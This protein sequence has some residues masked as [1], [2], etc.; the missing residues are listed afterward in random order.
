M[1]ATYVPNM[2]KS[3]LEIKIEGSACRLWYD[4]N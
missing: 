1:L 4:Q 3:T 2:R